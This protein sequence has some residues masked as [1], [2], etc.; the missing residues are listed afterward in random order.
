MSGFY[1]MHR[2]AMNHPLF[3]GEAFTRFQAWEWMIREA[4]WKDSSTRVKGKSI[5]LKRGQFT[6]SIRFMADAWGWTKDRVARFVNA[7]ETETMVMTE[8]ETG[9]LVITICKYDEYQAGPNEDATAC[10]TATATAARQQRDREERRERSKERKEKKDRSPNGDLVLGDPPDGGFEDFYSRFP[11]KKN[12]PDAERAYRAALKKG[13]T[14]EAIIRG[15]ERHVAGWNTWPPSDRQFIPGPGPWLNGE[16]WND[17][18][19]YR[20]GTPRDAPDGLTDYERAILRG[21]E[22]VGG[23]AQ[24]GGGLDSDGLRNYRA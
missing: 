7:L 17:E 14:H 12:R 23:T 2:D 15:L 21:I 10:E 9:Q 8:A 18:P 13:N 1:L 6:H 11:K 19:D 16:R 4:C 22:R 20:H 5:T 3:A 24:D